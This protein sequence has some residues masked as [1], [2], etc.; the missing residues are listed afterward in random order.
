V[1]GTETAE[2]GTTEAE[3]IHQLE[4]ASTPQETADAWHEHLDAHPDHYAA[5]VD[6]AREALHEG[7]P[8]DVIALANRSVDERARAAA[9]SLRATASQPQ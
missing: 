7:T 6:A 3:L 1:A 5:D 8:A 4:R 2:A 9:A